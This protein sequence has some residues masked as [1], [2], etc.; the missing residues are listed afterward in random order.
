M[1]CGCWRDAWRPIPP[2]LQPTCRAPPRP[3][4]L[5]RP[6]T[7]SPFPL[8]ASPPARPP[9]RP[10]SRPPAA[11]CVPGLRRLPGR[12][13]CLPHGRLPGHGLGDRRA[14]AARCSRLC[15]AH[16]PGRDGTARPGRL[17]GGAPGAAGE[18]PRAP[19]RGPARRDTQGFAPR[20]LAPRP[21]RP[22]AA[23]SQGGK[24]VGQAGKGGGGGQQPPPRIRRHLSFSCNVVHLPAGAALC[25]SRT[26][27]CGARPT[28]HAC[29]PPCPVW[30]RRSGRSSC[31]CSCGPRARQR[32]GRRARAWAARGT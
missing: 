32:P 6:F 22:P 16:A 25:P 9:S 27:A 14:A 11:H 29:L 20:R 31:H 21:L 4:P 3:H 7:P 17:P 28:L 13:P 24:G 5:S 12:A 8:C 15:A 10:L 1:P 30:A 19:G 23:A 26:H 18:E 2:P